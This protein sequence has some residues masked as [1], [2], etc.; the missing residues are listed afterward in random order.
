M[1]L[2]NNFSS[3]METYEINRE[4]F[5]LRGTHNGAKIGDG[6]I[7]LLAHI[8]RLHTNNFKTKEKNYCGASNAYFRDYLF[9][10]QNESGLKTVKDRL[11]KLKTAGFITTNGKT[12]NR[13]IYV[14]FSAINNIVN[15]VLAAE[16][17][18]KEKKE[19][20]HQLS[21]ER[22]T[23]QNASKAEIEDVPPPQ[24]KQSAE[25]IIKERWNSNAPKDTNIKQCLIWLDGLYTLS[26]EEIMEIANKLKL[27]S[28][29]PKKKECTDPEYGF[30][31]MDGEDCPF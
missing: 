11:K 1:D 3:A 12:I 9:L 8:I 2:K 24:P 5:R 7:N 20:S 22:Q 10:P 13:Q 16:P 14:D 27:Q 30:K 17:T 31:D 21:E 23:G 6:E 28:Y 29:E 25:K 15:G 4:L 19:I 18:L 26:N